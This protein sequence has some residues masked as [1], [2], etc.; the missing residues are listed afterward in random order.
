MR[1]QD[2][3]NGVRTALGDMPRNCSRPVLD[4]RRSWKLGSSSSYGPFG[5]RAGCCIIDR[6]ARLFPPRPASASPPPE[7]TAGTELGHKMQQPQPP[8]GEETKNSL[9]VK[10]SSNSLEGGGVSGELEA[11]V[12][13]PADVERLS[14]TDSDTSSQ[15][16]DT[17]DAPRELIS[18]PAGSRIRLESGYHAVQG[19]RPTME[20][21]H[22][23]SGSFKVHETLSCSFYGVYDGHGGARVAQ[24]AQENLHCLILNDPAFPQGKVEDAIR[25]GFQQIERALSEKAEREKWKDGST[26][27]VVITSTPNYLLPTWATPKGCSR[28]GGLMESHSRRLPIREAPAD[29]GE[30][31]ESNRGNGWVRLQR[32][33]FR[34]TGG[35]Q[36]FG[37]SRCGCSSSFPLEARSSS[38][39]V[40]PPSLPPPCLALCFARLVFSGAVSL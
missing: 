39:R 26:A 27:I 35:V 21:A 11:R 4:F 34:H 30:R 15:N 7:P 36:G 25:S 23:I 33:C 28:C 17:E 19:L 32:A 38:L 3:C 16:T 6:P 12:K 29:C 18:S 8:Q 24:Y 22:V 40:S 5:E 13:A 20:D 10:R 2:E 31:E 14:D 37:R 1:N 9:G